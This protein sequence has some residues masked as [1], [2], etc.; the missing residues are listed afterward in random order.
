MIS[1]LGLYTLRMRTSCRHNEPTRTTCKH[2]R[3]VRD[4]HTIWT[5]SLATRQHLSILRAASNPNV[6]EG[7][8]EKN[9]KKHLEATMQ[10][11]RHPHFNL[12]T[13]ARFA[14]YVLSVLRVAR[15]SNRSPNHSKNKAVG[16]RRRPESADASDKTVILLPHLIATHSDRS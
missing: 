9:A 6:R 3:F 4:I 16:K 11:P 12:C 14:R 5:S 2:I 10:E 15:C 1:R 8:L 7:R 13:K